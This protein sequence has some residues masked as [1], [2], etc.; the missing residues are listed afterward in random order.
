MQKQ[1]CDKPGFR[2]ARKILV[3]WFS[4]PEVRGYLRITIGTDAGA[5]AL[6]KAA[7]V[8][9]PVAAC[10][11]SK[12]KYPE[13]PIKVVAAHLALLAAR[14][15]VQAGESHGIPSQSPRLRDTSYP[16]WRIEK[17]SNPERVETLRA[18]R[19]CNPVGVENH[20]SR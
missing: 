5:D 8:K 20:H 1:E 12:I 11:P 18:A 13:F 3:R 16:G 14:G 15:V 2:G 10:F 7:A 4:Y 9:R 6:L 19:C 17:C